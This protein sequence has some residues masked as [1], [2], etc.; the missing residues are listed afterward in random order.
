[1]MLEKLLSAAFGLLGLWL[2]V[3]RRLGEP[4]DDEQ[5]ED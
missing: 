4:I 2:V 1:M 3:L 5:T